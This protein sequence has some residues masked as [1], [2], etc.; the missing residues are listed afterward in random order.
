MTKT[1][2]EIKIKLAKYFRRRYSG[3]EI[4]YRIYGTTITNKTKNVTKHFKL[5]EYNNFLRQ[6][7]KQFGKK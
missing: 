6:L 1:D 4:Q 2:R 3:D 7:R 5:T